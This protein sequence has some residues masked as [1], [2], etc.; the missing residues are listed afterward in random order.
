MLELTLGDQRIEGTPLAWNSWEVNLLARD[1]RLWQFAPEEA[2]DYR[3]TSNRFRSYSPSELRASLLREL[4]SGY[5]VSGTGH[6]MVAHPRGQRSL[7]AQRFEDLYR[8]FHRY[9]SV[10][11][12]D[13]EDPPFPLIGVVCRNRRDFQRYAF[14]H[15]G[16]S[17][18]GVL[19]YYSI[20][21]NRIILFDLGAGNSDAMDWAEN[22]AT[23]IHEATHQTAYNTGI[24]SRYTESPAWIAEGLA[25]LFEAPGVYNS[26]YNTRLRD[27]INHEQ[28]RHF[29]D[30]V[31][32]NHRKELLTELIASDRI[33]RTSTAAAYAE[34]WA[35]TLYLAE[36]HPRQYAAYL[37]RTADR[38]LFQ[39]YSDEE[40]TADFTA[41]F[42]DDWQMLEARFLRFMD[43]LQ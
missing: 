32:P 41:V 8:S 21:S 27:R 39:S 34:S 35:L 22:A 25:T 30:Y 33:F 4:G 3:K 18:A 28:H 16:I 14:R 40:R 36:S 37:A 31:R 42:G 17:G 2:E 12:F 29:V 11:G 5:E 15:D 24:H 43:G 1:G 13:V 26:R 38:P 9:F 19:G 23:V 6:Y 20:Q 10:R 7:W